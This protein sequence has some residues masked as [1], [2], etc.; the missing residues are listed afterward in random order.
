V[1]RVAGIRVHGLGSFVQDERSLS[2]L[3]T[4]EDA[5]GAFILELLGR[6]LDGYKFFDDVHLRP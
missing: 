5:P 4:N 1:V 2:L 6:E 3:Y